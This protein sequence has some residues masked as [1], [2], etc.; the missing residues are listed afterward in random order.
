MKSPTG[1]G[2]NRPFDRPTMSRASTE[3]VL[4]DW[5]YG[6]PQAERLCSGLLHVEGYEAVD[7]QCPLG[8]PDGLKDVLASR[9]GLR[10]VAGCY[11][12]PTHP[13]F[14]KIKTKFTDDLAGVQRN[15]ATAFVFFVNQPLTPGQ[16][17]ELL[18][19]TD[20]V[21]AEIYHV[22]R[23][24]SVLDSP[25]GY[26][27][28]LEYL[29]IAMS[30]EEQIAFWSAL[31]YDVTRRLLNN[32]RRLDTIAAKLDLVLQ[33]TTVLVDRLPEVASSLLATSREETAVDAETPTATLTLASLCWVHR[34]I[35]ES[36]GLPDA[37]RG[38]LRSVGV[39]ISGESAA[40]YNPPPPGEVPDL[41]KNFLEWWRTKHKSLAGAS[42]RAIIDVLA[43]FHH[44]FLTIHPFVDANGRV[45]RL[46]LDQAATELLG[47]GIGREI[48][49]EPG[50]YFAALRA[51][52]SGDVGPLRRLIEACLS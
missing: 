52:D 44:R 27:L 5:R 34:I 1:F 2:M 33:R 16:R 9:D 49:A 30:E 23:I 29:R 39:R 7:P 25:K 15:A 32:E 26:G 31:N 4:R 37:V 14:G 24:R 3:T 50:K 20:S 8:G 10:W 48:V 17:G 40:V 22:E 51:A 46:L 28:R 18:A 38:R 21:A 12:P 13:S 11:F 47:R 41:A 45:A 19:V 42:R 35:T 36:T 43:D 6:Q